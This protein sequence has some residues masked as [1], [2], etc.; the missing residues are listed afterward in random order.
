MWPEVTGPP[1][2]QAS[3]GG[4]SEPHSPSAFSGE[5]RE[6]ALCTV[7]VKPWWSWKKPGPTARA[8]SLFHFVL[9]NTYSS[10]WRKDLESHV[11]LEM[12]NKSRTFVKKWSLPFPWKLN[13]LWV[14][15]IVL[16]RDWLRSVY[17]CTRPQRPSCLGWRFQNLS[18][19]VKYS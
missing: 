4:I 6:G 8:S 5:V 16:S 17:V 12:S 7:R 9:E 10:S 3:S 1:S 14:Y 19:L 15:G 18:S 2:R 13:T 11:V